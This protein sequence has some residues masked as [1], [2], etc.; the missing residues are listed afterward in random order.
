MKQLRDT[1]G[2]QTGILIVIH[3]FGRDLKFHPH[4]HMLLT[5]DVLLKR[6]G[7]LKSLLF[8]MP[9]FKKEMAVS[10]LNEIKEEAPKYL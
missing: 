4:I 5:E 7:G 10:S 1:K 2:I 8:T 3:T 6:K 9:L